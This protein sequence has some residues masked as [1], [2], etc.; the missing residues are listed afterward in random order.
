MNFYHFLGLFLSE[1]E[2]T[3]GFRYAFDNPNYSWGD[4]S[5]LYSMIRRHAPRRLI[6]I[7]SG[8]SSCCAIDTIEHYGVFCRVTCI[9]P[10]PEL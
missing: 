1:E 9:E 8:W 6:E 10:Y 7:G 5:I 2:Q 3:Y 4:G